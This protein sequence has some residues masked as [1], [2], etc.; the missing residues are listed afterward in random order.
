MI[1]ATHVVVLGF[2]LI[3]ATWGG[4]TFK[5]DEKVVS[6]V[7]IFPNDLLADDGRLCLQTLLVSRAHQV[8]ADLVHF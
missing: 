1:H 2:W 7:F 8:K 4:I 3:G 5:F 6:S